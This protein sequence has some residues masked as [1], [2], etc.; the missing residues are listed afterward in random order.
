MTE[1]NVDALSLFLEGALPLHEHRRVVEHLKVC[2]RCREELAALRR[3]DHVVA[4]WG[5]NGR[6]IPQCTERRIHR[7]VEKHRR[8]RPLFALSR[9]MPAALGTSVAAVLVL[10]TASLAPLYRG[11]VSQPTTAHIIASKALKDQSAPLRFQ[12]GKSAVVGTYTAPLPLVVDHHT[13]LDIY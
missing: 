11:G 13:Q 4:A 12:R 6:A 3:V 7:S 9:M 10:L 1:C 2:S 5:A 8:L